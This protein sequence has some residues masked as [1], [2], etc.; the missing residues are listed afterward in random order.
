M[1]TCR[2]V[3]RR[4]RAEAVAPLKGTIIA[5]LPPSHAASDACSNTLI[6]S[7]PVDVTK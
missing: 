5:S 2:C 4:L 6:G 3:G 7:R 1:R